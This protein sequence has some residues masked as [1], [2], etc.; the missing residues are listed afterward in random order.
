MLTMAVAAEDV[1]YGLAALEADVDGGGP[2]VLL[3][4]QPGSPKARQAQQRDVVALQVAAS[5]GAEGAR[6]LSALGH[7]LQGINHSE[8]SCYFDLHASQQHWKVCETQERVVVALQLSF[9]AAPEGAHPVPG[10]GHYLQGIKRLSSVI[11]S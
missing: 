10:L 11:Y 4:G 3:A 2:V 6:P 7:Y 1:F 5:A 9:S 8:S